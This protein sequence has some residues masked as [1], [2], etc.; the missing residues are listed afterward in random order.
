MKNEIFNTGY[1]FLTNNGIIASFICKPVV[2]Y[3]SLN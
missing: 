2:K 1:I 3:Y